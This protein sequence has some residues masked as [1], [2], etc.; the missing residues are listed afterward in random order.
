MKPRILAPEHEAKN[1]P[2]S[3]ERVWLQAGE[4]SLCWVRPLI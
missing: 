4:T 2:A 1:D 3:H